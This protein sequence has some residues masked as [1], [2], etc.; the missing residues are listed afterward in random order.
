[1]NIDKNLCDLRKV[2]MSDMDLIFEWANNPDV[3]YNSFHNE[4]ILYENHVHWFNNRINSSTTIM[5]MYL[6]NNSPVGQIRFE[7]DQEKAQLNYSISKDYR[8]Q[9]H[10]KHMLALAELQLK[11]DRPEVKTI[12]AKV[13]PHNLASK[14]IFEGAGYSH[15][16]EKQL[17]GMMNEQ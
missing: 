10:G 3:R 15:S 14:S 16:Y 5:Y 7:I 4:K 13:M 6:Y 12:V 2:T 17:D 11:L 9:G 1:M 8:G